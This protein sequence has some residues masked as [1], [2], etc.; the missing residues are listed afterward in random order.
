MLKC[1]NENRKSKIAKYLGGKKEA[2]VN[3]MNL[4]EIRYPSNTTST[5]N[6]DGGLPLSR[7]STTLMK[8]TLM[9][10]PRSAGM[11]PTTGRKRIFEK[12]SV[13]HALKKEVHFTGELLKVEVESK[14]LRQVSQ[15]RWDLG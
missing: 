2:K 15:A 5:D 9:S 3:G 4:V 1:K 14:E 12:S 8:N 11:P 7:F 13:G 6:H 10:L